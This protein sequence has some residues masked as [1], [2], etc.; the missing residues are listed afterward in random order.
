MKST[1]V[2]KKAV[3]AETIARMADEGKDV[4]PFFRN[5][6][7][8]RKPVQRMTTVRSPATKVR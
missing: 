3:S 1:R 2:K 4:S 8:M 7:E 5:S 6:G